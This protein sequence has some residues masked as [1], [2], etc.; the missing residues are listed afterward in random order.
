MKTPKTLITG[1]SS[2]AGQDVHS[3]HPREHDLNPETAV[4]L[5]SCIQ[6]PKLDRFDAGCCPAICERKEER[7]YPWVGQERV[8]AGTQQNCEEL[9]NREGLILPLT[10]LMNLEFRAQWPS[11]TQRQGGGGV[12]QNVCFRMKSRGF[13]DGC[14]PRA[15]SEQVGGNPA[16]CGCFHLWVPHTGLHLGF[17][18]RSKHGGFPSAADAARAG[19]EATPKTKISAFMPTA[20]CRHPSH[21][22]RRCMH[23]VQDI[24]NRPSPTPCACTR[25]F[26]PPSS[27]FCTFK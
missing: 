9:I 1:S 26:A 8:K 11:E 5:M 21:E 22:L 4:S 19:R 2:F 15:R 23:A 20:I 3:R 17:K 18:R 12:H 6:K 25:T 14:L 24:H 13:F 10:S 7:S 27:S 16:S